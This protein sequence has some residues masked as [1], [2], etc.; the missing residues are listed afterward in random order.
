MDLIK[1]IE[2]ASEGAY[3]THIKVNFNGIS[4]AF[5]TLMAIHFYRSFTKAIEA[6]A[7]EFHDNYYPN[8]AFSIFDHELASHLELSTD[9]QGLYNDYL[10]ML[11]S[12]KESS[13]NLLDEVKDLYSKDGSK[14]TNYLTKYISQHFLKVELNKVNHN[15][16][17]IKKP[18]V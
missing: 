10:S 18:K 14:M 2:E 4:N 12:L 15:K 17:K 6:N 16:K 7:K 8:N 11:K 13:S 5:N 3:T 1:I 9:N